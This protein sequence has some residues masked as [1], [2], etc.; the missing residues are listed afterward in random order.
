MFNP[1]ITPSTLR[2]GIIM[3]LVIQL[4]SASPV[5][6]ENQPDPAAETPGAAAVQQETPK[7]AL[8]PDSISG[9]YLKG[10]VTDTG[11]MLSSPA[12]WDGSD[13]LKA[14]L[15]VGATSGLLFA[16]TGIKDFAQRNQSSAGDKAASVGNA[17]GNPLYTLPPLGLFYLYGHYANDQK[18]RHTSLLAVESLALSGAFTWGIKVAAGR[19]RP[20]T[21][22]SSSTWNGPSLKTGNTSFPS[23][24]TTAAFS[25]ASVIAEEYGANPCVPPI[26]YGL[27][28][29]T[30]MARIYDNKHWASDTFFGGAIG[31]FVGKAVVRYHSTQS[32]TALKILPTVSQQGFG[33][34]A[35]Y[36]F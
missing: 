20:Y 30:G 26:A 16:D 12:R 3:L 22:E 35:E 2:T 34:T 17:L 13:W 23:G 21:G 24:H 15:V 29:L 25:I 36:R 5:R 6:A 28:T 7:P 32:S 19:P 18:A 14:G 10:Y 9:E 4:L 11:K 8:Q 33:L 27:A 1:R 31:Y